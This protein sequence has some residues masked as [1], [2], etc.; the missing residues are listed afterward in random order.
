M[1]EMSHCFHFNKFRA[2]EEILISIIPGRDIEKEREAK[3][4]YSA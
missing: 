3:E 4:N 2:L 1:T